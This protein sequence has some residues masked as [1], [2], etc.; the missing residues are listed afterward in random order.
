[1]KRS[2]SESECL[3]GYGREG[4]RCICAIQTPKTNSNSGEYQ[5]MVFPSLPDIRLQKAG[6]TNL[7]DSDD[8]Q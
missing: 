2:R 6:I 8:L 5:L 7:P 1:M 4:H 3:G